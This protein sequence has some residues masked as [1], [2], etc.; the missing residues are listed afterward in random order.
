M[1]DIRALRVDEAVAGSGIGTAPP[2]CHSILPAPEATSGLIGR[3]II[4]ARANRKTVTTVERR[5]LQSNLDNAI[6][7]RN[8]T[9]LTLYF[10]LQLLKFGVNLLPAYIAL[11]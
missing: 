6:F 1:A 10:Q 9:S 3:I 11:T 5:A 8:I 4:N 7:R 2:R